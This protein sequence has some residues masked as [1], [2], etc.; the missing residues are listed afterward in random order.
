[1]EIIEG[2]LWR[3]IAKRDFDEG[4]STMTFVQDNESKSSKGVLEGMHFQTKHTQ[5]KLVRVTKGSV[6]DVCCRLKKGDD[7]HTTGKVYY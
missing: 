7:E 6:Y 5:G 3:H 4:G 1:M 2:I